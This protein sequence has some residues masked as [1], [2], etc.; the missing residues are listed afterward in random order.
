MSTFD[1]AAYSDAVADIVESVAPALASLARGNQSASAFHWRDGLFVTADDAIGD[2]DEIELTL[3]SGVVVRGEVAGRDGSTGIALIRT[4]G[5]PDMPVMSGGTIPRTGAFAMVLGSV[6]GA[7]LA[8]AGT[9]ALVGPGWRTARGAEVSH[10]IGLGISL[11]TRFSGG[12]VLDARGGL[13]GMLLFNARRQILVMPHETVARTVNSLETKGHV[14]RGYLGANLHPVKHPTLRGAM[15][16][17]LDEAG[18]A[19]AAGMQLGD[20]VIAWDGQQLKDARELVTLLGPSGA[21]KTV[22]LGLLRGGEQHN[23]TVSIGEKPL[24]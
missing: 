23:V 17:S 7:P 14:A 4:R 1:L 11:G 20:I 8:S 10:R 5:Q 6:E 16:T 2:A 13:I 24:V 19:K 21:G 22:R 3:A 18:P 15:V 12:P 9:V